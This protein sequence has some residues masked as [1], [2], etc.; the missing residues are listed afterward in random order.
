MPLGFSLRSE[1]A[2]SLLRLPLE[3]VHLTQYKPPAQL[4]ATLSV[5]VVLPSVGGE[6]LGDESTV[7]V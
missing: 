2:N 1:R 6:T 3:T 7:G 5:K 4:N